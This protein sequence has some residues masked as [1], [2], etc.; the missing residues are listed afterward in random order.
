MATHRIFCYNPTGATIS[1]TEQVGSIAAATGVVSI[2]PTKQWWNGPDE[3]VRYIVAYSSL[4]S[5]RSNGP[6]RVLATNYPCNLG[7]IGSSA[8]TDES[9]LNLA[10]TISGSSSLASASA[11]KTWLNTNGY[12]TSW[13]AAVVSLLLDTYS[14]SAA[15]YSL[16]KLSNAYS[17]S[18]IRVRRS[19]DNAEQDIAFD[20]SGNLDQSALTTFVGSNNGFVTTWY[21]Q[22]GLGRNMIQPTS[23]N[24]PMIVN[25]GNVL[26][27][28]SKPAINFN[29]TSQYL[30]VTD[31]TILNVS[32]LTSCFYVSKIITGG[33]NSAIASKTY[34]GDGGYFFGQYAGGESIQIWIDGSNMLGPSFF[35]NTLG[36][37]YL[38]TNINTTG[39]SGIKVYRNST[40]SQ[41]FT[42]A[43]DLSG[44]NSY[45]F[46][47]GRDLPANSYLKGDLQETIIYPTDQSSDRTGIESNINTFY[48]IY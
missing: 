8:K 27:V 6:E 18:A 28:N 14:G 24:Q 40:T 15:A 30:A 45:Y 12:W 25:S 42:S 35:N 23:L 26:T 21:D 5:E 3:D 22:S 31:N 20:G 2:D 46:T 7:F 29:G 33:Y 36:N 13:T 34:N 19:S 48:S 37:Q 44:S 4:N 47:L 10:K 41:F 43:T 38:Y 16:R 39:S 1:G 17:G 9:F 11:A 32:S